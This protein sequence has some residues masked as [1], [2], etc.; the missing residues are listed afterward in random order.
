MLYYRGD[1]KKSGLGTSPKQWNSCTFEFSTHWK[2]IKM[3]SLRHSYFF[4]SYY[5]LTLTNAIIVSSKK[6]LFLENLPRGQKNSLNWRITQSHFYEGLSGVPLFKNTTE[7]L[8]VSSDWLTYRVW[9]MISQMKRCQSQKQSVA[10]SGSGGSKWEKAGKSNDGLL[11]RRR[12]NLK[13][14]ASQSY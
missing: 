1:V 12:V 6:H 11:K 8:P 3:S 2:T 5:N 14:L 9:F 10:V 7:I 4:H 13:S